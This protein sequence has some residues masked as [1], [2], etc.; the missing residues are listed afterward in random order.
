LRF[1]GEDVGELALAFVAPLGAED[2]R[3]RHVQ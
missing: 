3:R 2:D 1:V